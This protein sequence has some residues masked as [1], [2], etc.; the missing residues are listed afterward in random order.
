MPVRVSLHETYDD[1]PESLRNVVQ[2]P[3][4][5]GFARENLKVAGVFEDELPRVWDVR[6]AGTVLVGDH[7]LTYARRESDGWVVTVVNDDSRPVLQMTL[8]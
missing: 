5:I 1:V 3:A 4:L 2:G 7:L 6:V 8:R